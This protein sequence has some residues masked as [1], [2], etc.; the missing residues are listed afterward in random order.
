MRKKAKSC[1]SLEPFQNSKAKVSLSL[2]AEVGWKEGGG[3]GGCGMGNTVSKSALH[4]VD[5]PR[6]RAEHQS[7]SQRQLTG[8]SSS[9][10]IL[11]NPLFQRYSR[12]W[13][14]SLER[15]ELVLGLFKGLF[16]ASPVTS[17]IPVLW[18]TSCVPA[19]PGWMIPDKSSP[20]NLRSYVPWICHRH[21][22]DNMFKT[23]LLAELPNWPS[24]SLAMLIKPQP[25]THLLM[26]GKWGCLFISLSNILTNPLDCTS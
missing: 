16:S 10:E 1:Q 17:H 4:H 6:T 26:P 15:A 3:A 8:P 13:V 18:N 14:F 20:G 24:H 12:S 11:P 7:S 25:S 22:K 5:Q 23:E 2:R 19:A 21:S 9:E